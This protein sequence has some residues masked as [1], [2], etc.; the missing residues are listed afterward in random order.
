MNRYLPA[1]RPLSDGLVGVVLPRAP[2]GR[3]HSDATAAT[4]PYGSEVSPYNVSRTNRSFLDS[5]A[6]V[7]ESFRTNGD[8][9]D[10]LLSLTGV[11]GDRPSQL[12]AGGKMAPMSRAALEKTNPSQDE[13]RESHKRKRA[14]DSKVRRREQCRANQARYR[15]KQ[16]NAQMQLEKSVAQLHKELETLK[17]RYRD[18][19]SRERSNQSPWSIIAEVFR[20]LEISFR[21]PWRVVGDRE[22]QS[23]AETRQTLA[24]L[25]TAF[26]HDAAMGDLRGVDALMEQLRLYSQHFGDTQLQLQRVESMAPGVMTARAKLS[27]TVTESTLRHIFPHLTPSTGG[28]GKLYESLLGQRLECSSALNFL[29]SDSDRVERL[30]ISI[31]MTTPLLRVLGTVEDVSIVLRHARISSECTIGSSAS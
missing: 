4:T 13:L 12:P 8:A 31:D 10:A 16:R 28:N 21:S 26:A 15:D 29:F 14:D 24:V 6:S 23:H 2:T 30:E 17:R 19:S 9:S 25:E 20:L 22:T 5:C 3:L 27:V 18:L 11:A 1:P 7:R